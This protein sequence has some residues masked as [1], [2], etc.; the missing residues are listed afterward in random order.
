MKNI[1][2]ITFFIS[3]LFEFFKDKK[4]R[5]SKHLIDERVINSNKFMMKITNVI[6]T[7]AKCETDY[8]D[9]FDIDTLLHK[10]SRLSFN[11]L[12]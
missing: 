1:A 5:G 10:S 4:S 8:F 6:E 7:F 12:F 9:N 11:S 2:I 3:Y